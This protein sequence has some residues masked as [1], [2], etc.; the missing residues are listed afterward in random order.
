[1]YACKYIRHCTGV[2]SSM[3][4]TYNVVLIQFQFNG[5]INQE[6]LNIW[7]TRHNPPTPT[8]TGATASLG[9][10]AVPTNTTVLL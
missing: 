1:M 9:D 2:V 4:D 8:P 6:M 3:D 5:F 7:C 10:Q